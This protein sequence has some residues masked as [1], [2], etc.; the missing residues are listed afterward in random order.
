MIRDFVLAPRRFDLLPFLGR[1]VIDAE[2]R[3]DGGCGID[4]R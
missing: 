4:L 3:Q 2:R 1:D